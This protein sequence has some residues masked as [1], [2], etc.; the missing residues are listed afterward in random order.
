MRT[1]EKGVYVLA[2]QLQRPARI[3]VGHLGVFDFPPGYYLYVGSA[4]G[5]FAGRINRHLKRKKKR[6][7]HIDYLLEFAD[8]LWVDLYETHTHADECRLNASV[9]KLPG[10]TVVVPHFGSS[11]CRCDSHLHYFE[12]MPSK[13]PKL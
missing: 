12:E 8:L 13:R 10:A 5:G 3:T 7:W 1:A 4:L 9:A 6:H 2:M 11:D